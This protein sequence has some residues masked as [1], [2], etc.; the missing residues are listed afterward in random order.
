MAQSSYYHNKFVNSVLEPSSSFAKKISEEILNDYDRH[1][2][3]LE[4]SNLDSLFL[5]YIRLPI[6]KDY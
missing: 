4:H 2:E 1:I 5:E 6:N 3:S